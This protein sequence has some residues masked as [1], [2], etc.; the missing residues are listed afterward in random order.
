M[1]RHPEPIQQEGSH[2]LQADTAHLRGQTF[3]H[4]DGVRQISRHANQAT[5]DRDRSPHDQVCAPARQSE[6]TRHGGS[7]FDADTE[8]QRLKPCRRRIRED[9]LN[10]GLQTDGRVQRQLGM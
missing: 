5:G 3:T 4:Q 9:T 10:G 2:G 6:R 7:G 8:R 1:V